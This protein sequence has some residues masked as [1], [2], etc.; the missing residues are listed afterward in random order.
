VVPEDRE[1]RNR[2]WL[3]ELALA[4]TSHFDAKRRRRE[5]SYNYCATALRFV[6]LN[7]GTKLAK[8]LLLKAPG[9]QVY[10]S[11]VTLY[12]LTRSSTV[13]S[14]SSSSFQF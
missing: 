3:P 9:R 12:F 13:R 6:G 11:F 2:A 1:A 7:G 4:K 14:D 10:Y 5:D 8:Y